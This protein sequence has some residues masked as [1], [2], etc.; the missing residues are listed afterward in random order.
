MLFGEYKIDTMDYAV[1]IIDKIIDMFEFEIDVNKK[2]VKNE[3]SQMLYR[4]YEKYSFTP[5]DVVEK[6]KAKEIL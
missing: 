1:S 5:A 2:R 3:N 4:L 6:V